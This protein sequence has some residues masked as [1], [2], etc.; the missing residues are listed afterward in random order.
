MRRG[1]LLVFICGCVWPDGLRPDAPVTARK[2]FAPL[3][4]DAVVLLVSVLEVPVGDRFANGELWTSIDE[5]VV[6][7]DHKAAIE[8]NGFRIGVV[9]G[10]RPDGFD[11][12]ITK[13]RFNPNSRALQMRVG[14]AR[15]LP[16]GGMR[17]LCL[18]SLV[19]DGKSAA[20]SAFEQS[21][22]AM[23]VTPTFTTDGGV[24]L[25][26]VPL[27]Q[28]GA[29][30]PWTVPLDDADGPPTDTRPAER[31]PALGWDVS[32][33]AKD[34]VVIGTR[35]EKAGTLGHICFMDANALKPVQRLLVIQAVRPAAAE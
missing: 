15:V 12:L 24:N 7:L 18:F 30:T 11:D 35:F 2:P 34:F 26:F 33:A 1:W 28:H 32:L 16:L 31:F 23:Q 17:K 20:T 3:G 21:Q 27:I 8:D 25:A 14:N 6:A 10:L 4:A 22:C 13:E 9:G 29:R 19:T 5:Q